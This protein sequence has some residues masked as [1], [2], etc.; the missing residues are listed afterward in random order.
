MVQSEGLLWVDKYRPASL[1]DLDYHG[2]L[3]KALKAMATSH[4]IPH[5]LFY[6]PPGAGKRTR[7][8]G[9]L[10]QIYGPS[11]DKLKVEHRA[12][13]VGDPPKEVELTTVSSTY[14]IEANPSDAGN[15]DRLVVQELIKEIA[16][17]APLDV[18]TVK[19]PFKVI[20]LHEVDNLSR[21]AQQALRRTMEKYSRTCRIFLM[22]DSLTKVIE[23]LR[24]RCNLIRVPSPSEP[25]ICKI[26]QSISRKESFDLPDV[27]ARKIVKASD[28]NLGRAMLQLQS[29]RVAKYPF[30]EDQEVSRADWELVC[31]DIASLLMREQ[32]NKR[33]LF[34][35]SRFYELLTHAIPADVIFE[36]VTTSLLSNVDQEIA[37]AICECAAEFEHRLKRGQ[38]AIIHLEAFAAK[39][40]Q[41]YKVF[42]DSQ[43]MMLMDEDDD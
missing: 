10:R 24:S 38:K 41:I 21:T 2:D 20:V 11:I 14:H 36:K 19:Q 32:S 4:D 18:T 40:M 22:A 6:G 7:L 28:Y 39:F 42:I 17:N 9:L 27:F 13:K 29:S 16:S 35:R 31:I 12:F 43:Y 5:L 23:P 25:D 34:V 1:D 37:P 33:L 3:T 30:S 26:L 8:F 15:S